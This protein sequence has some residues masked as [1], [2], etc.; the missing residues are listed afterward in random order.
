M[1]WKAKLY[2]HNTFLINKYISTNNK[3]LQ[4]LDKNKCS[5]TN[6]SRGEENKTSCDSWLPLEIIGEN[7]LTMQ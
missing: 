2:L 3:L 6:Q 1:G 5:N 4:H 7:Y